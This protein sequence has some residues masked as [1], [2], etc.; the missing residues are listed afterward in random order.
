MTFESVGRS[1]RIRSLL[2]VMSRIVLFRPD[3]VH[4]QEQIDSLTA[5]VSRLAGGL[6]PVLLTVHDP[7][8]HT[9]NDTDYVIENAENRRIIRAAAHAFH[10]HGA[11]CRDRT[12]GRDGGGTPDP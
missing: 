1:A 8:P 11:S 10:V 2:V 7:R 5:W 6:F 12:R 9:G 4:V 3:V